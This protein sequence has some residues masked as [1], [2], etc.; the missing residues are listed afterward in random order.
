MYGGETHCRRR[1]EAWSPKFW[2][3]LSTN[4]LGLPLPSYFPFRELGCVHGLWLLPAA[5]VPDCRL[6]LKGLDGGLYTK[7][8]LAL[9]KG[10][11]G[12]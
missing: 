8:C 12:W 10:G 2:S 9:T 3:W 7:N 11:A 6:S 4:S 1:L 5:A